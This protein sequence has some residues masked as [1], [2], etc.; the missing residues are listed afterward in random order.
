MDLPVEMFIWSWTKHA[1]KSFPMSTKLLLLK[2]KVWNVTIVT[3]GPLA[4]N[5]RMDPSSRSTLLMGHGGSCQEQVMKM[6][7]FSVIIG[8]FLTNLTF[9]KVIKNSAKLF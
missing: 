6:M 9:E 2:L 4:P 1:W 3:Y 5:S 8:K 7:I